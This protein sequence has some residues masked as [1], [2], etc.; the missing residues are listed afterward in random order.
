MFQI[1]EQL[2]VVSGKELLE[3]GVKVE[4]YERPDSTLL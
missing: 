3:E 2:V 1:G 4:L